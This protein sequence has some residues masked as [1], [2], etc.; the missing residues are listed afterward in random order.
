MTVAVA[1]KLLLLSAGE[2]CAPW[3]LGR[4]GVSAPLGAIA[5]AVLRRS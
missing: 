4:C 3:A 5:A 1:A 2:A